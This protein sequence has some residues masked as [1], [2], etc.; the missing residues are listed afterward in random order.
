MSDFRSGALAPTEISG[1][2]F[3][4]FVRSYENASVLSQKK[5]TKKYTACTLTNRFTLQLINPPP[6][7]NTHFTLWDTNRRRLAYSPPIPSWERWLGIGNW[8]KR[9]SEDHSSS[10]CLSFAN[11]FWNLILCEIPLRKLFSNF[12]I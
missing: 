2:D 1:V 3:S 12:N 10:R 7:K 5:N 6:H 9:F 8:L 11:F 4:Y